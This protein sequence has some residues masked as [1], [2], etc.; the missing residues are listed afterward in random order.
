MSL[1][2]EFVCNSFGLSSSQSQVQVTTWIKSWNSI[3]YSW[4]FVLN[5]LRKLL[6]YYLFIYLFIYL[7]LSRL[8]ALPAGCRRSSPKW[9]PACMWSRPASEIASTTFF[10]TTSHLL[11]TQQAIVAI[12]FLPL[13]GAAP[14]C[15]S[16]SIRRGV[17]SMLPFVELLW[18][19]AFLRRLLLSIMYKK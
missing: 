9:P 14:W 5:S 4:M 3:L 10:N 1:E 8:V 15:V 11:P 6:F 17:K 7:W 12:R 13:S 2:Q 16:L 19:Y 18:V